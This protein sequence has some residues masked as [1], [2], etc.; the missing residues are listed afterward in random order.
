MQRKAGRPEVECRDG[1]MRACHPPHLHLQTARSP[2][3]PPPPRPLP[4]L[5]TGRWPEPPLL[6]H[7]LV[8]QHPHLLYHL[9]GT[10]HALDA[11]TLGP[12]RR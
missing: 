11:Q 1:R 5:P 12:T 2:A 8:L 9:A 7:P 10:R 4:Q 3:L 6:L